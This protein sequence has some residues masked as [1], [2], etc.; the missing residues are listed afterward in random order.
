VHGRL[1]TWLEAVLSA[2]IFYDPREPLNLSLHCSRCVP[3]TVYFAN[4]LCYLCP[5]YKVVMSKG[6]LLLYF[7]M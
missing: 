3:V 5:E 1:V 7:V 6:S 4:G 2:V